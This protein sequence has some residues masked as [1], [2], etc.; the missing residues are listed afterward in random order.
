MAICA[1]LGL[2][3]AVHAENDALTARPHRAQR[4]RRS[5][6]RG[7][8]SPS[9]RR[10]AAR[11]RSPRTRAARCT[12]STS[13][14]RRGVALVAEARTRG[15][16]V[17]C[18]TCPH[19]LFLTP[20]DVETLGAVAKCA[21]PVRDAT[22]SASGCGSGSRRRG[23]HASP[24]TTRPR[25]PTLKAGRVRATPGAGSR[26]ARRTLDAAAQRGRP[27]ARAAARLTATGAAERFGIAAQGPDRGRRGRRP[28]AGRPRR[29]AHAARRGPAATA[30]RSRPG[31]AAACAPASTRT[32]L[33]GAEAWPGR[34]P[35]RAC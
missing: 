32:L 17:T 5:W 9:S 14:A 7:P 11:S 4:A 29:R 1:R 21:P 6:P 26:A 27:R 19:Y 25:R 8:S 16:D 23:R 31:S 10:S 2:L 33:R 15:V 22:P 12:S 35:P 13:P 20:D 28:R 24:P 3:V 18:E 30:T 34:R